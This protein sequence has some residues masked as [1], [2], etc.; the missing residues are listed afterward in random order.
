[1]GHPLSS[2]VAGRWASDQELPEKPELT[3]R[4]QDSRSLPKELAQCGG[5]AEEGAL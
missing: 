2:A 4:D 1:M 5:G 3:L